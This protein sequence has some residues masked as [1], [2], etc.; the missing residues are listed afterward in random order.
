MVKKVVGKKDHV[1]IVGAGLAG[2]SAALHLVGAGHKVTILE[3]DSVPGG[4]NVL[5]EK[6]GF[7]F[8]TGPTV[9]TMPSLIEEALSAVGE[10]LSDW[11]QLIPLDPLYRANYADGS[12][13]NVYPETQRMEAEIAD[14]IGPMEAIG[15]RKYV[16]FVTKL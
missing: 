3:R 16:D 8:D 7:K 13:L 11:L 6:S 12:I 9:L 5:L 1:V 15:Y 4:R 14:V 10:N 2:L